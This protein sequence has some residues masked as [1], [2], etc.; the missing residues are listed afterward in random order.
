MTLSPDEPEPHVATP[1]APPRA[2]S[3]T[4]EAERG[5]PIGDLPVEPKREVDAQVRAAG[6]APA[7]SAPAV[8]RPA[9]PA[10]IAQPT[11]SS[12]ASPPAAPEE[13]LPSPPANNAATW[14]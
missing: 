4:L 1:A 7:P 10:P 12:S 11:V 6:S 8:P 3:P 9:A 2:A 14:L 5:V 13:P